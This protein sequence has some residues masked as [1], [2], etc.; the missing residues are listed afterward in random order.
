MDESN[1]L[2]IRVQLEALIS[3]REAMVAENQQRQAV[4]SSM[5]YDEKAFLDNA[6]S[7]NALRKCW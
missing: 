7:I 6:A 4:G 1:L 5:A 3:E 2:F